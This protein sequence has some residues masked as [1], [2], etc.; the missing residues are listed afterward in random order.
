VIVVSDASVI[1]NLSRIGRLGLLREIYGRV[2]IPEAVAREIRRGTSGLLEAEASWLEVKR[3]TSL[4]L[5]EQL[6]DELDPGESEAIALAVETRADF[7]L[8][9]EHLGRSAALRH[10]LHITGLLGVL[11]VAKRRKLIAMVAPEIEALRAEGFWL[12]AELVTR[13]LKQVGEGS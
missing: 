5:I 7:L 8:I 2:L 11:L 1:I 10:G 4:Q 3:A 6:K 12:S 9:D 13:V